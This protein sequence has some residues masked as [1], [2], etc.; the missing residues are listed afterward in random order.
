MTGNSTQFG[1]D[2]VDLLFGPPAA[3]TPEARLRFARFT[4]S[5]VT[6][7]AGC[8]ASA[9]LYWLWGFWSL[10]LPVVVAAVAAALPLEPTH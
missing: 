8:A 10:A 3:R 5:I 1:I 6:F 7:M 2:L 4:T 9:F